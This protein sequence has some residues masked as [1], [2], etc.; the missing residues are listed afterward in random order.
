MQISLIIPRRGRDAHLAAC[1]HYLGLANQPERH[2]LEV[3]VVSAD[4]EP[5]QLTECPA[6]LAVRVLHRPGA[7]LAFSRAALLNAG[8]AALRPGWE[9]CGLVDIDMLY[10]PGA[11]D[12][13]ARAL[14]NAGYAVLTGQR[15]SAAQTAEVLKH[16]PAYAEIA[17]WACQRFT[18]PSQIAFTPAWLARYHDVFGYATLF[19]ERFVGWG[20]QDTVPELASNLLARAGI[21]RKAIVERAWHHLEH[22]REPRQAE[23]ERNLALAVALHDEHQ[24]RLR[25]YL[26]RHGPPRPARPHLEL[27]AEHQR[28]GRLGAAETELR[29]ALALEPGA[30]DA[31]QHL[32]ALLSQRGA[33]AEAIALLREAL[34]CDPGDPTLHLNLGEVLR[35]Q[36]QLEAAEEAFTR[37]LLLHPYLPEAHYNLGVLRRQQARHNE[38]VRAFDRAT[39]MRPGYAAAHFNL[40]NTL[41]DLGELERALPCYRAALAANPAYAEAHL[42]LGAT[43]QELEQTAEA[44]H[45]FEQAARLRPTIA[46]AHRNLTQHYAR[47]GRLADA[48]A[49]GARALA[50]EPANDL[51]RLALD[52]LLPPIA[53]SPTA[54]DEART[55]LGATIARWSTRGGVRLDHARAVE[56]GGAPLFPLI[57]HGRDDRPLK[58]AYAALFAANFGEEPPRAPGGKPRVG[59]LVTAGHE[60]VFLKCM[61]GLIAR[62]PGH[63]LRPV[64]LCGGPRAAARIRAHIRRDDLEVVALPR[65]LDEA[66]AMVRATGLS[67]LYHW[68]VGTDMLNYLLPFC[69]AAP[70]QCTGWGWPVTSGIPAID[71]YLSSAALEPPGAA[72]HYSE[73]LVRIP[74]LPT[75]YRRPPVPASPPT[76]AHFGLSDSDNLYL[77]TQ[78]LRKVHPAMDPL[79][80]AILRRD[81]RGLAIF[82]ADSEPGVTALLSE[83]LRASMPDVAG[84]LRF[85]P[86]MPEQEYLGLTA[87]A[88]VVL[89]TPHYGAGANTCLDAAAAGTPIVTLPG[90]Y[91][92]GRW[93]L[94]VARALDIR[95]GVAL[96]G[97]DY[98]ERAL[99]IAGDRAYRAALGAR[100]AAAAP[101]LFERPEPARELASFI[102]AAVSGGAERQSPFQND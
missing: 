80:A 98:V 90:P 54:I 92:R 3:L 19:D 52:T 36:G 66:A 51:L 53:G 59:F 83:R 97:T 11:L 4:E 7:G 8:I 48:R 17:G 34:A 88:N 26:R 62:L 15:L 81:P 30:A 93:A 35:R 40:G 61:A 96:D 64:V 37:A 85:L 25:A 41:R 95:D 99:A 2:N 27:A 47:Q 65:Q 12:A 46:A 38:A 42:N 67:A 63:E 78:N 1:L 57:Y 68:E 45:H 22:E 94:A 24:S 33:H 55:A 18:T 10:A 16:R 74:G 14:S 44:A 70:I 43:L 69:R 13:I 71:Y 86:R 9:C 101:V 87:I 100:I 23:T 49:S 5:P 82:I 76:R 6:G 58:E 39:R 79:I 60:G 21:A 56:A 50:L 75:C 31:S 77:C 20:Y 32:A 89:D 102:L 73:R 91:Q 84:Q 29:Q 72:A 28:A